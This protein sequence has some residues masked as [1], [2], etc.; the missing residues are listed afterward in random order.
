MLKISTNMEKPM[1]SLDYKGDKIF[2]KLK[3][4]FYIL[5]CK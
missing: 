1:L 2:K 4:S 3:I 5:S